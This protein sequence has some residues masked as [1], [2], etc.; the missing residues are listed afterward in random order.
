MQF[1]FPGTQESPKNKRA[2]LVLQLQLSLRQ[3]PA[4]GAQ[5]PLRLHP[6]HLFIFLSPAQGI[7]CFPSFPAAPQ[8]YFT[9]S[10]TGSLPFELAVGGAMF[11]QP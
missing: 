3:H 11:L 8:I 2:F 10:V 4:R 7:L 1:L 6:Q 5:R 9:C